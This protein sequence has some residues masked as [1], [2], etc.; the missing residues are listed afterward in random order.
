[1]RAAD[2]RIEAAA[3]V[4]VVV[5]EIDTR[6]GKRLGLPF[7]HDAE[8]DAEL[9]A[10]ELRADRPR[11]SGSSGSARS[12]TGRYARPRRIA[13]AESTS[14]IVR[15]P[16]EWVPL[17]RARRSMQAVGDRLT[18]PAARR[19]YVSGVHEVM[20]GEQMPDPTPAAGPTLEAMFGRLSDPG[21]TPARCETLARTIA[22]V[23]T[24]KRQRD[25]VILAHNYQRPEV[26]QVA[27]FIGDSLELAR[28]ATRVAAGT[29]VFCGV[30]FMAETAKILNPTRR[31]ILPDLR[32]GCSLADRGTGDH[33][34][35]RKPGLGADDPD[36]RVGCRV[37]TTAE[38]Q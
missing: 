38:R 16:C 14:S 24:L 32:A 30:H 2:G 15:P 10:R 7:V 21:Y 37:N 3:G 1:M 12:P 35:A 20:S 18:E 5:H 22:E 13:S 29:I 28:Q 4:E 19:E 36:P 27:D 25:A 33:P 11:G 6:T 17:S 34:P 8:R 9:Q 31:V 23:Q 26:L